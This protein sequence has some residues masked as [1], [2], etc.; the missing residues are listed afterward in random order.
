MNVYRLFILCFSFMTLRC[1]TSP[2]WKPYNLK[3][4]SVVI[5]PVADL[6]I[7][8]ACTYLKKRTCTQSVYDQLPL[9]GETTD[10]PVVRV[11]Q[12]LFNE[13]LTDTRCTRTECKGKMPDAW[14]GIDEK[15]KDPLTTFYTKA[16]NMCPLSTLVS[17]GLDLNLLPTPSWATSYEPG[18]VVSLLLPWK[19]E[20]T[21]THYSAGT[22]F[23][24]SSS[25]DTLSHYAVYAINYT[26]FSADIL[27]IP[28]RYCLIEYKR[29]AQQQRTLFMD[30]IRRW[31]YHPGIIPYVLGGA[32]FLHS[33]DPKK[34]F[35]LDNLI[36]KREEVYYP[37]T[38]FD[39]ASLIWRACRIAGIPWWYKNTATIGQYLTPLTPEEVL[40]EGDLIWVQGHVMIVSN[41]EDNE[42]IESAGYKSGYGKLH[43]LPI[44]QRI[45]GI[46]TYTDLLE[47]Y[48]ANKTLT[49]LNKEGI[50]QPP[51][52]FKLYKLFKES[53]VPKASPEG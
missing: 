47:A 44:S 39:C 41:K 1:T 42:L 21:G 10:F 17:K 53:E 37:H 25:E 46:T 33:Y 8:P 31:T 4:T 19:N 3:K 27:Y 40:Q 51:L 15:T 24:R 49:L 26:H 48:F 28:R 16:L 38:G 13:I 29:N 52:P 36:W 5:V 22:R 12:A 32:S 20:L 43:T 11:H 30:I 18:T 7:K 45:A 34:E 14:Y 23:K 2:W 6:L 9:S 50:P 35:T